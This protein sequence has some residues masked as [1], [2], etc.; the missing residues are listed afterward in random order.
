MKLA[1]DDTGAGNSGLEHILRLKPDIIKLDIGLTRGID[2]DP[3]RRALGRALLTFG[4]DAYGATFVAE[5]IETQGEFDTLRSLGCLAGQGYYLGSAP[6]HRSAAVGLDCSSGD[7]A[8]G[9]YAC[10]PPDPVEE[11]IGWQRRTR[12]GD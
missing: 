7:P 6:T 3:A 8:F 9:G 2:K 10:D 1:I 5:G 4:F 12:S 11:V